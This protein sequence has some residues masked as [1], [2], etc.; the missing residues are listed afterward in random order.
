MERAG[1]VQTSVFIY[2]HEVQGS[3]EVVSRRG[4]NIASDQVVEQ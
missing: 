2:F 1:S 3:Q 4:G